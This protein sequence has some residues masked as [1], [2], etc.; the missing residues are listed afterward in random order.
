MRINSVA[1]HLNVE[2]IKKLESERK[3]VSST[4]KSTRAKD[5]STFSSEAKRLQETA[6]EAN[7]VQ[8]QVQM[9]PEIRTDRIEEVKQRIKSGYYN[10]DVFIDKLAEKIMKDFGI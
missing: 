5:A 10:S 4:S 2:N 3:S 8:A 9:Q 1:S 6:S 7:T